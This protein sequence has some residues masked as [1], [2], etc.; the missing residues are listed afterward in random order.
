[1]SGGLVQ[2]IWLAAAILSGCE[3][4]LTP[5]PEGIPLAP[6]EAREAV[7]GW[8]VRDDLMVSVIGDSHA[9][10]SRGGMDAVAPLPDHI[11]GLGLW[12]AGAPGF[13]SARSSSTDRPE[14]GFV[15]LDH[16]TSTSWLRVERDEAQDWVLTWVTGGAPYDVASS[17]PWGSVWLTTQRARDWSATEAEEA[18]PSVPGPAGCRWRPL[19]HS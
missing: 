10:L 5:R 18:A 19:L 7:A 2:R 11:E 9:T 15:W 16:G 8:R 12:R 3:Q 13:A 17:T 1:M 6:G 4:E 14:P